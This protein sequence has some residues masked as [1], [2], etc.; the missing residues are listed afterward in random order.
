MAKPSSTNNPKTFRR[1]PICTCLICQR[2]F[3]WLWSG[4]S[5][6]T[7]PN[8]EVKPCIADDTALVCGKVG[9]RQ[10]YRGERPEDSREAF[11]SLFFCIYSSLPP[12]RYAVVSRG[13]RYRPAGRAV[14][15]RKMCCPEGRKVFSR[16][17]KYLVP[18]GEKCYVDVE[19]DISGWS[20]RLLLDCPIGLCR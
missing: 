6:L 4:C 16:C 18:I 17:R 2:I 8:R 7:I 15:M 3:W 12:P 13:V 9:R 5:P 19:I 1:T 14:T 20:H 10:S 11:G